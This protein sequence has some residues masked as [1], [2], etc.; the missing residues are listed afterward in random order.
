LKQAGRKWYLEMSKVFINNLWFKRSAIDHLVFFK[1]KGDEHTIVAVT[2]D[3]MA[4]TSKRTKDAQRFKDEVRKY[5]DITDHG[6]INWFLGFEIRRD[7]EA[8]TLSIN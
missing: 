4:V 2:T 1:R 7:R 8:K 3:D 5:W 6:P